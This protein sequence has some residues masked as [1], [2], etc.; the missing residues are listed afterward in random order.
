MTS[1]ANDTNGNAQGEQL[2]ERALFDRARTKL[3]E[4][5]T[6]LQTLEQ[7]LQNDE[8]RRQANAS[9]HDKH[10]T[11]RADLLAYV[12]R[13][14]NEALELASRPLK[15]TREGRESVRRC[16]MRIEAAAR[17]LQS[18]LPI[19]LTPATPRLPRDTASNEDGL[20]AHLSRIA[21]AV[22]PSEMSDEL[23]PPVGELPAHKRETVLAESILPAVQRAR[24]KSGSK[25]MA[26]NFTEPTD[27]QP[28]ATQP[29]AVI[30]ETRANV[31]TVLF[32]PNTARDDDDETQDMSHLERERAGARLR[33]D[34]SPTEIDFTLRKPSL[35]KNQAAW[36]FAIVCLAAALVLLIVGLTS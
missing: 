34:R 25:A 3:D 24:R 28:T 15:P 9:V 27:K 19:E 26:S 11:E 22:D 21:A 6:L 13:V 31:R 18:E 35:S 10:A 23:T 17:A 29:R 16:T 5:F 8:K 12:E 36:A 7:Q 33:R 30:V 32:D 1:L 2:D 20:A 14:H 4:A